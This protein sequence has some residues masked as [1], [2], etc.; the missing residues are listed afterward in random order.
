MAVLSCKQ[1]QRPQRALDVGC[2]VGRA[3]FELARVYDEVVGIDYRKSFINTCLV[4]RDNGRLGYTA[5]RHGEIATDLV[6][7]VDST[8]VNNRGFSF[9][10]LIN[11]IS[12]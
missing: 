5:Q 6:A 10:Q 1:T 8:I 11:Q 4:L 2:G 12:P 7:V 3:T 9:Y